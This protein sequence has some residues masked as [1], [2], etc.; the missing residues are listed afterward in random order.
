M[1]CHCRVHYVGRGILSMLY[2][3]ILGCAPMHSP[4]ASEPSRSSVELVRR[5]WAVVDTAL[6][7]GAQG[8]LTVIVR[9]ADRPMQ[10]VPQG[11]VQIAAPN[12]AGVLEA[13]RQDS[14]GIFYFD[15]L[16]VGTYGVTV[17]RTGYSRIVVDVPVERGCRTELEVFL[18]IE[19]LGLA[20]PPPTYRRAVATLCPK[21]DARS[22]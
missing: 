3:A 11:L 7:A 8:Q 9:S 2:A 17:R 19:F 10:L 5:S 18:G 15:A 1:I 20:P 22:P 6:F 16:A 14:L 13:T 21:R 12:G 4:K